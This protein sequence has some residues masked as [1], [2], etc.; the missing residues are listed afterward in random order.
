MS[1]EPERQPVLTA[2]GELKRA[3]I[4]EAAARL[5]NE[6]G[7]HRTSTAAI[8]ED[9]STA[10]ATV[11]HYFRAKH[12]I[13][14]EI[15]QTWIDE[16]IDR[17]EERQETTSDVRALLRGVFEDI[18]SLMDSKPGHVRVFF[19]FFRELPP[20]LRAKAKESRDRYESLVEA[21]IAR[22]VAEG[23]L[24]SI[25]VRTQTFALFGICNWTYQWFRRDGLYSD[26]E[27]ATMLCEIFMDGAAR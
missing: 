4:I 9:V 3:Q 17:F 25:D 26:Q 16:L 2:N 27:I 24:K 22:G 19:E 7:Y 11:Y 13:L 14:Y 10:K 21:T 1:P 23:V 20:D 6:L 15:H 8:A 5:F 12:D 18:L